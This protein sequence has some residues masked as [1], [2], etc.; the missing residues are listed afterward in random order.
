MTVLNIYNAEKS[1]LKRSLVFVAV[2]S[3]MASLCLLAVPLYLTQ[4][5]DRVIFAR[6]V[7]TLLAISL[8]ALI[9]LVSF[10]FLD[11]IRNNLLAK[12]GIR[13]EAKLSGLLLGAELAR[14]VGAQ[15]QSLFFLSRIRQ[16]MS[17]N[18]M[19]ALFDIP[20]AIF[21]VLIVFLIHPLLG[22]IILAGMVIL[23]VIAALGEIFTSKA[24][25]Q[26]QESMLAV[27]KREE[28]AFRQH[29]LIKSMG[30]FREI[31]DDWSRE[32]SKHLNSLLVSGL[33]TNS[34]SSVSRAVRQILQIAIIGSGAY[35]VLQDHVTAG[36]IF[37]A[38]LIGSR[39]LGPVEHLI[40]GWRS[41]NLLRLNFKLLDA[42]MAALGVADEQTPLPRPKGRIAAEGV[43]FI[44]PTAASIQMAQPILK[45]I[46]AVV[47]EGSI[48]AIIGPSGAGKSTFAKCLVGYYVPQRGRVTLGGQD[49]QAWHPSARGL[50]VGYLP[51]HIDFFDGTVRENISRMRRQD[52]P[53][54]AVDAARFTGVHDAIM[55]FPNGYDTVLATDGFQPSSG[56]RQLIALARAFYGNPA[57]VVLDEPNA[58]LDGEGEK[59][60]QHCLRAAKAAGTTV[61]IVT[62]RMSIMRFVD[63]VMI[64]KNGAI[65]K[66]GPPSVVLQSNNVRAFPQ[67]KVEGRA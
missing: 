20:V 11:A 50:Y 13:F 32:Q 7:D 27:Q 4:V 35:L 64:L 65:E 48:T 30:I 3:I 18:V 45:G 16:V 52:D 54:F 15:R 19:T 23:C 49:L 63:S 17:S 46:S 29:E 53:E 39:A 55:K 66:H 56:Q 10:G 31:V 36:I 25:K 47:P 42:R 12:I 28:A 61:I 57:V 8:I 51:Q 38:S 43:T 40:A 5:Y 34:F 1:A 33:R 60:L 41:I 44:W 62:Q 6:N 21:F 58:H 22:G 2:V 24:T 59:M 9:V 37:A 67:G 14:S 26:T